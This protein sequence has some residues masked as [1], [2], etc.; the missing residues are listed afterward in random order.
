MSDVPGRP[1]TFE[2]QDAYQALSSAITDA[3]LIV[4]E[5]GEVAY[6]G[7]SL[8]NVLGLDPHEIECRPLLD[9][10]H[11][12]DAVRG[13]AGGFWN[14][15]LP[16]EREFRMRDAS[17]EWV[18]VQAISS[19]TGPDGERPET[20]GRV[21]GNQS[22]L[23]VRSRTQEAHA[24]DADDLLREAFNAVNNLVVVTDVRVEDNPLV[25][26]NQNFLDTTGYTREEVLG[27][28][29]RFLQT[30]PDG[31]RDDEG[32]GQAE[33]LATI[34][35]AVERG[36]STEVLLRN[37]KKDGTLF[38][39]RLF[40]TP[41][42]SGAGQVTH[43]VGVQN[44]VTDEVEG[45][46]EADQQ[47]S[48]LQSF[49]DGA[50][51]LM[52][53]VE[54]AGGDVR[55]RA[56]NEAAL[57]LF[58]ADG[59]EF[60]AVEGRTLREVGFT[61][62]EAE[63]WREAIG[64]CAATSEAVHFSTCFPWGADP[65]APD[66]RHLDVVV[67]TADGG[68]PMFSYVAEDV[69]DRRAAE[70]ERHLLS[71][72][73]E[74]A[75]EA[76]VV[77]DAELDEPGPHILYANKAHERIFGYSTD[78]I[79]GRS[80]RIYQGPE[81]DRAVLD[82]IRA[83]LEAGEAVESESVNY[84][85]DGTPFVLQWEI[86]PVRD[87]SGRVVNWVGT[88]RDVTERRRLEREV[89]EVAAMEQERIARDLHDGLGQILTGASFVL[90]ALRTRLARSGNDAHA[91]AARAGELVAEALEQARAI[92]RGLSPIDGGP[93][94]LMMALTGLAKDAKSAHGLQATFTYDLPA[95]VRSRENAADLYRIAQEALSNA[96][97][98]AH[99]ETVRISIA[100]GEAGVT[101]AVV[102]DGEGIAPDALD[103]SR[104]L[105]MR[106]MRARAQRLG[107]ELTVEPAEGGGTRVSVTFPRAYEIPSGTAAL[108]GGA[109][110]EP[111]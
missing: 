39:N 64:E 18:W 60:D 54:I 43:F 88:Q 108:D 99:A 16:F 49:F 67:N 31:T 93:S 102:D 48:L 50:S 110:E 47:R 68:Q 42:R 79:L 33:A 87:G 2:G 109:A 30:R 73:V 37:Y 4:R 89:L 35:T 12:D 78:E 36:A 20:L 17:G 22:L 104:G 94:A 86:A 98:H 90:E 107:G 46:R 74:Q 61:D 8:R 3:V 11:P 75:A 9:L 81:T 69:T 7:P 23:L 105:G 41:I 96:A 63:R 26:V 84:R 92:A 38:Y 91:D 80:P 5:D 100:H 97:R 44:D 13:E 25:V 53:V 103:G 71:A 6:A 14:A 111:A 52:G 95:L 83:A 28:N 58:R 59:A 40:L 82:Q 32:D 19:R 29:C 72:A 76:I 56:A 106:S 24:R 77:T 65:D 85:K 15:A 51:F 57:R 55:H 10:V 21:L 101:L 70:A 27:Q 62:E 66:T 45:R 1:F 34:R